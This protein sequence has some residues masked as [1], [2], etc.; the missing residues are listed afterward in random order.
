VPNSHSGSSRG[1]SSSSSSPV[2]TEFDIVVCGGT[3]GI[4]IALALQQKGFRVAVVE[5]RRVEGRLQEWNSSRHEI[6]VRGGAATPA[7]AVNVL[8]KDKACTFETS[9]VVN[10][11]ALVRLP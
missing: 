6:Q 3:L 11:H 9:A 4:C 5:K 1:A 2:E 7:C 8:P 10:I